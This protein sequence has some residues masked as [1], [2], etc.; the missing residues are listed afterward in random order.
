MNGLNV[1]GIDW[2]GL[3]GNSDDAEGPQSPTASRPRRTPQP[4]PKFLHRSEA[5]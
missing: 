1:N 2:N 4:N 5:L 3:D